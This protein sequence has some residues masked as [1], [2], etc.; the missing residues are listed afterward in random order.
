MFAGVSAA[1]LAS[2]FV[3][4]I[5]RRDEEELELQRLMRNAAGDKDGPER[6]GCI[7]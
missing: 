6:T 3:V 1:V 2:A 7:S 4:A 5:A